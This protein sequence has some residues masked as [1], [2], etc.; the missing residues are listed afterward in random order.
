HLA[1]PAGGYQHAVPGGVLPTYRP[2]R[3]WNPCFTYLSTNIT[4]LWD[5]TNTTSLRGST[6]IPSLAGLE[7]S[8][9]KQFFFGK[10]LIFFSIKFRPHSSNRQ[11][12]QILLVV[13]YLKLFKQPL[14]FFQKCFILVMLLLFL[15]IL[16][17]LIDPIFRI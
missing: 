2:W 13:F 12:K 10:D 11:S 15:D 14:V 8:S 1:A 4:S 5:S 3:D 6:N 17:N 9:T 7:L 16:N